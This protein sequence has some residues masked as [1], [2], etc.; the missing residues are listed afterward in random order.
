MLS[1]IWRGG[2]KVYVV[3]FG[4]NPATDTQF[5]LV[6]SYGGT[7]DAYYPQTFGDL[8]AALADIFT[9]LQTP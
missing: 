9:R 4:L 6:A 2:V 1:S 8:S 5:H 3:G 7:G